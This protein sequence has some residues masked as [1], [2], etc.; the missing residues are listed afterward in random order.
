[1]VLDA[2]A[3]RIGAQP[4]LLDGAVARVPGLDFQ[5][6]RHAVERLMVRAVHHFKTMPRA[7]GVAQRLD[8]GA[9][10]LRQ[11]VAA[12]VEVQ[13]AAERDIEH[14][15]AFANR[16]H[17]QPAR[18]GGAHGGKLPRIARRL[19]VHNQRPLG[20]RLGVKLR[21]DVRP[22]REQQA[23]SAREI[24]RAEARVAHA[25]IRAQGKEAREMSVVTFPNP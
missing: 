19:G 12:D 4:H 2:H 10:H 7:R 3:P 13:R 18:D 11:I 15:H 1:M 8:V 21:R 5:P 14:L 22:A 24:D 17:R 20:G 25:E 6:V 23:V 9:F 16:Q